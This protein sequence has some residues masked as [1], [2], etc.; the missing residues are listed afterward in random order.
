MAHYTDIEQVL[1]YVHDM[2]YDARVALGLGYVAYGTEELLPQYPA[3]V[4][5]PGP[6]QRSIHATRQF[7]NDFALE[8][9]CLHANLSV[10]RRER[11]KEDLELVTAIKNELHGDKTLGQNIVFGHVLTQTPG[12]VYVKENSNP[13]VVTRILWQ[14]FGLE[15]FENV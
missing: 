7:R 5:T 1:D 10:S 13:V 8:I 11:T 3:A 2:L 6:Q 9:W 14:G 15:K 4:V 12:V